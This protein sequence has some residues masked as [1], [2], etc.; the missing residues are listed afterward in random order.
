MFAIHLPETARRKVTRRYLAAIGKLDD[1]QADQAWNTELVK[2]VAMLPDDESLPIL[3][4]EFKNPRL[5]DRIALILAAKAQP[6]DRLRFLE[7]LGSMQGPVVAA[8]ADAL[9]RLD[10][11]A[12]L[13]VPV[14]DSRQLSLAVR[15]LRRF[16]GKNDESVR[17]AL[18]KLL[19]HWAGK[20]PPEIV[21]KPPTAEAQAWQEWFVK[22]YPEE[23]K[24]LMGFSGASAATWKKR[25]DRIDW[26]TGD[27]KRGFTVFQKRNCF[28]C[29]AEA[30]RIGPDL[31]GVAQRFSVADLFAHIVEPSKDISPTYQSKLYM[32]NSGKT[33]SGMIVYQSQEVTLLQTSPD[34]TVRLQQSDVASVQP[35]PLSFMPAGLLDDATD[36]ELVDLHAYLKTLRK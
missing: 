15:A 33:Y 27:A 3:R 36:G 26:N 23:A 16:G 1:E 32:T 12:G 24:S 6:V 2:L 31:R 20:S 22:K 25:I 11:A 29:H 4:D 7:A 13:Q 17:A 30:K 18:R 5:T 9:G 10:R 21:T 28:R 14:P 34:V 8:A 19:L 35:S